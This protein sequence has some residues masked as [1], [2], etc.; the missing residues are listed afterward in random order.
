MKIYDVRT[1]QARVN[2]FGPYAVF[3]AN[4]GYDIYVVKSLGPLNAL[5]PSLGP[6]GQCLVD[7]LDNPG[8]YLA[9]ARAAAV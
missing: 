7:L 3:N 5:G 4:F 2:L 1:P 8:L 9:S 6:L